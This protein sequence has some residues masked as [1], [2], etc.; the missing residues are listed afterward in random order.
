MTDTAPVLTDFLLHGHSKSS[1]AKLTT[2]AFIDVQNS[3][4]PRK[5]MSSSFPAL[6]ALG[7][8]AY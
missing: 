7:M 6:A 2:M 3:V 8:E 4:G 1:N 5:N